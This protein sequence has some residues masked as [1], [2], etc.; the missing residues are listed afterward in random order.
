MSRAWMPLYWGDYLRDTR[1]L[2]T[3]QHGAYLLLIAHYWQ[4]GGLPDDPR[5]L[6][7]IAGVALAT[8]RRIAPAIAAK[9]GPGWR[10]GRIDTEIAKTERA[11][12]QRRVA[13]AKGGQRTAIARAIA[14]GSALAAA[15]ARPRL[16]GAAGAAAGA[17]ADGTAQP[18][19]PVSTHNHHQS[20]SSLPS[21]SAAE[22]AAESS[23]DPSGTP[24]P[25]H[26]P[27]KRPHELSRAEIEAIHARRRAGKP[28][29]TP[30]GAP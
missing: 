23:A 10:H 19:P 24:R 6:A 18:Q 29:D 17:R 3:L 12:T 11:I 13:G 22:S 27:T 15:Q 4:H 5:R 7:A 2:S 9:F 20:L 14:V 16:G 30:G 21:G 28:G 8:W 26:P 1:D 25:N